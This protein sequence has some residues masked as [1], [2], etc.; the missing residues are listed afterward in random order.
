MD[1]IISSDNGKAHPSIAKL[2]SKSLNTKIDRLYYFLGKRHDFNWPNS[3]CEFLSVHW[4]A[5]FETH[6]F[7][8]PFFNQD[9]EH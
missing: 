2:T 8:F 7:V 4:L 3:F 5:Q 1:V 9:F 6:Q